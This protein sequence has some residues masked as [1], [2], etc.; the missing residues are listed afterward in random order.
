MLEYQ[1]FFPEKKSHKA[2]KTKIKEVRFKINMI[3]PNS[4]TS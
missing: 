1:T 3:F 2:N 4:I